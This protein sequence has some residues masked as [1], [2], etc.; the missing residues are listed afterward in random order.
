MKFGSQIQSNKI[1]AAQLTT[2]YK[3]SD[4][5]A[6]LTLGNTDIISESGKKSSIKIFKLM[7]MTREGFNCLNCCLILWSE[8]ALLNTKIK[9]ILSFYDRYIKIGLPKLLSH[10]VYFRLLFS[11]K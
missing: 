8:K 3:G 4:F 9:L 1:V 10:R 5:T 2:D 7:I 11:W 6:S